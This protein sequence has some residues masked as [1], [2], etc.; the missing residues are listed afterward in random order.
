MRRWED[1]SYLVAKAGKEH[2]QVEAKFRAAPEIDPSVDLNAGTFHIPNSTK[3]PDSDLTGR[4]A[5]LPSMK[6]GTGSP[7]FRKIFE[8]ERFV[9]GSV[10][11][12]WREHQLV[13]DR[14]EAT[15]PGTI[16]MRKKVTNDRHFD[17]VKKLDLYMNT[18]LG[19]NRESP[20][21]PPLNKLEDDIPPPKVLKAMFADNTMREVSACPAHMASVRFSV[22]S[23]PVD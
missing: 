15:E 17:A 11:T 7:N 19:N 6:F 20:Y 23:L 4:F 22:P 3:T 9:L 8:F 2:V 12:E 16:D 14:A 13:T 21:L 10:Y 5:S 18:Q 1:P